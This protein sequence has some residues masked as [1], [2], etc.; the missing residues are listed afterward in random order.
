MN[1]KDNIDQP[2]MSE[3]SSDLSRSPG[4]VVRPEL[5][6][7]MSAMMDDETD[8]LEVR[9]VVKNLETSPELLAAWRRY[10][11]VRAALQQDLHGGLQIDLLEGV[12]AGLANEAPHTV[13][14]SPVG[15]KSVGRILRVAGQGLVA[16]SVA[17]AVLMVYPALHGPQL[18]EMASRSQVAQPQGA[19]LQFSG[20]YS[21]SP[22]T[23]TVSLDDA[24]RNR[25]EKAVRNFSGTS[26]VLNSNTMP[27]FATQLEPFS[28]NNVRAAERKDQHR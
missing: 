16:A 1:K 13:T 26:A 21:A 4:L 27:M 11:V 20:D 7:S 9:R 23:R 28:P 2:V 19:E 25:L 10:H 15:R 17:V 24:A 3:S 22:L 18:H 8:A 14:W 6:E 12:R 5:L